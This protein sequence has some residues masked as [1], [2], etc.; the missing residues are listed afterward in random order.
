V[1]DI[2]VR[3]SCPR[4]IETRHILGVRKKGTQ[5]KK[6]I[7]RKLTGVHVS[8]LYHRKGT[9]WKFF[10]CLAYAHAQPHFCQHVRNQLDRE[11]ARR[12][13]G[14]DRPIAWPPRSPDLTPLDFLLWGYV[15]NT[16]YQV[17]IN[18]L[19]R[20]GCGNTKHVSSNV[21][22]GRI[23]SGYFSCHQ[24]RPHWNLLRKLYTQKKLW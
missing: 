24:G 22:R 14:R 2:A 18:G 8:D 20:C 9:L 13:I 23:S 1:K 10:S 5:N 19:Q 6:C 16:V 3:D 11:L 17:K 21:E 12:W 15:K 7:S 4:I